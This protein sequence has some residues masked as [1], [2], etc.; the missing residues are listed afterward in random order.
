MPETYHD[1]KE[2]EENRHRDCVSKVTVLSN[3]D[4][5]CVVLD[6]LDWYLDQYHLGLFRDIYSG[7]LLYLPR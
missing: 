4:S 5:K 3:N 1:F 6:Q 2:F 7:T